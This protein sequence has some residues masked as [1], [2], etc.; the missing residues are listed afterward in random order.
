MSEKTT[1]DEPTDE[2]TSPE[3]SVIDEIRHRRADGNDKTGASDRSGSKLR[4]LLF[5]GS[6]FIAGYLVGKSQSKSDFREELGEFNGTDSGPMEIEIH[7]TDSVTKSDED[8]E[9]EEDDEPSDAGDGESDDETDE[10]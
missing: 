7:D 8:D 1:D 3:Q 10:E 9:E 5:L 6:A 4:T 2:D